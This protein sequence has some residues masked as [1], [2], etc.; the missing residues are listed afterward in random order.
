MAVAD[1][2]LAASVGLG[3]VDHRLGSV[4]ELGFAQEYLGYLRLMT[5]EH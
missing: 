1:M 3:V 2:H 4:V 5:Q